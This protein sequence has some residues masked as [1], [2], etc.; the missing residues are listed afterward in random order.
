M[1]GKQNTY[2]GQQRGVLLSLGAFVWPE[3]TVH[4]DA[5]VKY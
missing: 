3:G 2:R 5:Q 4:S 1:N